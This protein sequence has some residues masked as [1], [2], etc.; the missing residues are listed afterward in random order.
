M[1][2]RQRTAL[3]GGVLLILL[4]GCLLLSRLAPGFQTLLPRTF[5]WPVSLV[6]VG[7]LLLVIGLLSGTPAMAI[8]ACIVGG[9]GLILNYQ[10]AA[11]DWGS[12]LY[13]WTLIPG[14]AGVGTVLAGILGM[15]PRRS[16][17]DGL[18]TIL[19]SLV[20]FLVFSSIFGGPVPASPYWPALLI[21]LG[22]AELIRNVAFPRRAS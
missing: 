10:N 9:I 17:R 14:F 1:D 12:W 21:A 3:A 18:W 11:G 7:L 2:Q 6:G 4:G 20:L 5:G 16:I 22:L 13:L 19:V 15:T 8:P